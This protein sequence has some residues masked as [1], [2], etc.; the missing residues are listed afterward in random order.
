MYA[1]VLND[2]KKHLKHFG[3]GETYLLWKDKKHS[4]EDAYQMINLR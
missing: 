4:S 3:T 1:E 2:L